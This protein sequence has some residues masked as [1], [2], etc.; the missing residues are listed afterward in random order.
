M[1][2]SYF[3]D[4]PK[5][6]GIYALCAGRG[7]SMYVAYV[8]MA[9]NL[10]QRLV[11]HLVERDSSVVTGASAVSLNPDKVSEVRWWVHE[12]FDKYLQEAE[13]V[14]FEVLQPVLRSRQTK[15][16]PVQFIAS[17]N[18]FAKRMCKVFSGSPS[19]RIKI[20]SFHDVLE[21]LSELEQRIRCIERK[22][23]LDS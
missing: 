16:P 7:K 6:P 9:S 23:L 1:L 10:R 5:S 21:K 2:R 19:G 11:H 17:Q 14:A 4:A 20:P 18:P 12:D 22:I 15:S 8:G 13:L 3:S